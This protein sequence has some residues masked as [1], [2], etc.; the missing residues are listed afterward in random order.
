MPARMRL[1]EFRFFGTIAAESG[2]STGHPR[3]RQAPM[4]RVPDRPD[5]THAFLALILV[6]A[7][8]LVGALLL[9][10]K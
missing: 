10:A 4:P 9:L 1:I 5:L 8:L 2:W 7:I 6:G 3:R